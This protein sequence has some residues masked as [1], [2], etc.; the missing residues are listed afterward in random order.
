M[1][2]QC[3]GSPRS[4]RSSASTSSAISARTGGTFE[5]RSSRRRSVGSQPAP[6]CG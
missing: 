1:S 6:I 2:P 4:P 3:A 5:N